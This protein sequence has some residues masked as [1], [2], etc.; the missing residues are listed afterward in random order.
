MTTGI[1]RKKYFL[2][3]AEIAGSAPKKYR[4]KNYRCL[5]ERL[6]E[7]EFIPFHPMDENRVDDGV[8]LRYRFGREEGIPDA[9]IATNLDTR[10]CSVLEIMVSLAIRME[11]TITSD[12]DYGDRTSIWFW[13]MV[14]SMRLMDMD[15]SQFNAQNVDQT[16]DRM[17]H[18][19]YASN[20]RGGLF[21]VQNPREDMRNVEIWY[22]MMWW[23]TDK[24]Y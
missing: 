16:L 17:I 15:D 10:E 9:E 6:N 8:E 13:D 14:D 11:E 18:R 19:E 2:W 1:L 3:M 7:T 4:R 24:V 12:P 21:T 22:Q 5:L 23:L 20:G